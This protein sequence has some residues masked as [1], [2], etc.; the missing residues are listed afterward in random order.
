M[1]IR[2]PEIKVEDDKVIVSAAVE[3]CTPSTVI[4]DRLWYEFPKGYQEF[5]TDRVDGFVVALFILAMALGEDIEVEGPLSPQLVD[6]IYE[7]QRVLNFWLPKQFKLID[8]H[9]SHYESLKIQNSKRGVAS[10]F[11]GGLDS[12]HTLRCR[13]SENERIPQIRLSHTLFVHGFDIPLKDT[14]TYRVAYESYNE[15]M[16]KLGIQLISVRTN[17]R[18]FDKGLWELCHGAM[19]TSVP[20]LLEQLLI[21]Y[22]IPSTFTYNDSLPWGSDPRL[23]HL[24]STENLGI[25]HDGATV[26]RFEKVAVVSQWAEAYSRLRVCWISPNGLMNCGRCGKCIRVMIALKIFGQLGNFQTFP[27]DLEQHH[28]RAVRLQH[29]NLFP[30]MQEAFEAAKT[31]GYH[32]LASDIQYVIS[33]SRRDL[34]K[35]QLA[36]LTVKRFIRSKLGQPEFLDRLVGPRD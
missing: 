24:L 4:P 7:Y 33:R 14:E 23:D 19:L 21:R 29:E 5:L 31:M 1:I 12:F 9:C 30:F 34:L 17:A 36:H 6:G 11:S 32:N 3:L 8:I 16:Q 22:Y 10:S 15:L 27:Q 13:L 20:I 18:K 26:T 2:T 35:H 25:V 28:I